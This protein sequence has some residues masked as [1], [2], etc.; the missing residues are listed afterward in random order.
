[1][2]GDEVVRL[3]ATLAD[4]G[5]RVWVAGGWA[6]DALVG[7]TTRPHGDLD[8]AVDAAQ[9]PQSL[10]LLRRAGFAVTVDWSPARLELRHADGRCLDVHPVEFAA[11]GGG[12]QRGHE[13]PDFDYAPDG[14]TS[15]T[16]AGASVPCLSAR[17]QLAFRRGYPPRPVDEHDVAL[18]RPLAASAG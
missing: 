11:D 17:Q 4:D 12:V 9:L 10:D 16:I 18:L 3:L 7:R 1:M 15:G 14:F 6:V 13:G 2:T 5:I 8:V